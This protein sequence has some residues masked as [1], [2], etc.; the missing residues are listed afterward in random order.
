MLI[1]NLNQIQKIKICIK[2]KCNKNCPLFFNH[3]C[4]FKNSLDQLKNYLPKEDYENYVNKEINV[5]N[6]NGY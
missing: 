3:W 4:I 6:I 5:N 1:V 2:N